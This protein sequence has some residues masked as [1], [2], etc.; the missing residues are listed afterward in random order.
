MTAIL[1]KNPYKHILSLL[2]KNPLNLAQSQ[3]PQTPSQTYRQNSP[4][5]PRLKS[6][7]IIK[8]W[9]L[10]DSNPRGFWPTDLK[11]VPLT[12]RAKCLDKFQIQKNIYNG[13]P[14]LLPM[15]KPWEGKLV[16]N[17][18]RE[19]LDHF[20]RGSKTKHQNSFLGQ[21]ILASRAVIKQRR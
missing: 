20:S 12:T 7:L 17:L 3:L 14:V 6:H 11:S 4:N 5:N 10:W 9:H 1:A 21:H 19:N 13:Q 8:K 16:T 18:L 2:F 15:S